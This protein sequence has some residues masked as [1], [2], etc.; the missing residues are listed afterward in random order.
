MSLF[1][2][3]FIYSNVFYTLAGTVSSV[4]ANASWEDV[5]KQHIFD[6]I[7]M[8]SAMFMQDAPSDYNG[9]A[10]PY[11][12]MTVGGPYEAIPSEQFKYV[13]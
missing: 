6:P 11:A 5:V 4:I 2:T 8:T 7:G 3:E 13:S 9:F 10:V 12:R 1:R